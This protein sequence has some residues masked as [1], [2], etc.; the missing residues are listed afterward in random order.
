MGCILAPGTMLTG[1]PE[2]ENFVFTNTEVVIGHDS[3]VGKFCTLFPK[4]EICVIVSLV[5][6]VFSASI[7]LFCQG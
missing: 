6:R 4:V 5:S 7:R 2:L 3:K 1:D